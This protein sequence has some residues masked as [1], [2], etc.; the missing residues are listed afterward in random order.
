MARPTKQFPERGDARTRLLEAARD[1]IRRQGF[2]ASSVEDF[3][4]EAGVTKGAFFHQ[5]GSKEA[6]GVAAADYWA[7]TTTAFF[8]AAPYHAPKDPLERILAYLDFR[9]GII[10]GEIAEF[11]CLVGTMAQEVYGSSPAI[12]DACAASIFGHAKTLVPDIQAAMEARGIADAWTAE[13][14]AQHFQAVL[15]GAFILAKAGNDPAYVKES[16][17]H[18][19]RYVELLFSIPN[20]GKRK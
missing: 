10:E 15:Q 9:A 7:E 20:K 18:L 3:C 6:L 1:T 14:L 16:I 2:A 5:F 19:R 12:R 4:R 17:A 13:S 8:A 11:T